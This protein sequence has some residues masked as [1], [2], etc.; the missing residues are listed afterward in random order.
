MP[1]LAPISSTAIGVHADQLA[2]VPNS[3]P[4]QHPSALSNSLIELL[5]N[6]SDDD[7]EWSGEDENGLHLKVLWSQATVGFVLKQELR[8]RLQV[9]YIERHLHF[10]DPGLF[11]CSDLG[12][13]T[14]SAPFYRMIS[15]SVIA[16]GLTPYSPAKCQS[17]VGSLL[18]R[19]NMAAI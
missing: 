2:N 15:G 14:T 16:P 11:L 3:A 13:E 5:P 17:E 18:A 4:I 6:D 10:G 12:S 7:H 1:A 8:E 9:L 19:Q